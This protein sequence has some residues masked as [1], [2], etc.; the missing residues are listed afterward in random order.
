M[1]LSK[2]HEIAT[3]D[4]CLVTVETDATVESADASVTGTG[5][6]AA[7]VTASAFGTA[8]S[9][10]DG[11]YIFTAVVDSGTTWKL[12][13]NTVTLND[14]GISVTGTAANND[15]I[16]V[17]YKA[18]TNAQEI[19]LTTSTQVSVDPQIETT[20]AIKLI[21]KAVLIAQKREKQTITGNTITLTDN[22]FN[23]ELVQILQGGTIT[24][25]G[26][27]H[28]TAYTPPVAGSSPADIKPFKLSIYTAQYDASGLIVQYEKIQYPNCTGNPIALSAQDDVFA[29]PEYTIISAPAVGQAPYEITYVAA[30]PAVASV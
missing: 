28:I 25:D 23:P 7:S 26:S 30:L 16:T 15:K 6:T 17:V 14:Y 4:V 24:T 27:G 22:V 21:V 19:G 12:G 5:I 20:D 29:T 13:T 3:I 18:A 9:N 11:T 1:A 10:A 8:V 2:G